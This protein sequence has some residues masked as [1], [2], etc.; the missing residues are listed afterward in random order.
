MSQHSTLVRHGS[1][2]VLTIDLGIIFTGKWLFNEDADVDAMCCTCSSSDVIGRQEADTRAQDQDALQSDQMAFW[3]GFSSDSSDTRV[4][5]TQPLALSLRID[6]MTG[7]SVT[8]FESLVQPLDGSGAREN[9][10][11]EG[12]MRGIRE[13]ASRGRRPHLR[14]SSSPVSV[15]VRGWQRGWFRCWVTVKQEQSVAGCLSQTRAQSGRDATRKGEECVCGVE[16]DLLSGL[17]H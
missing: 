4:L 8:E 13:K 10:R 2:F 5:I 16:S 7:P 11:P 12:E 3:R 15:R 6:G 1:L 9:G 17:Q 14:P